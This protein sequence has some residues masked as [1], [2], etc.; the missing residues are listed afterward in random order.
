MRGLIIRTPQEDREE[1][2]RRRDTQR[3][4]ETE[5]EA[6]ETE[7]EESEDLP[8]HGVDHGRYIPSVPSQI[9][10]RTGETAAQPPPHAMA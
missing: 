5:D 6:N 2:R 9:S 10:A 1:R 4:T 7:D 8:L 3:D